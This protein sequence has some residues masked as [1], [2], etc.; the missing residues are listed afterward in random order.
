MSGLREFL[1]DSWTFQETLEEGTRAGTQIGTR[2]S[3]T[4]K[5][6]GD[7]TGSLPC[8]ARLDQRSALSGGGF[9][10]VAAV[11]GCGQYCAEEQGD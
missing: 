5:H 3:Y 4:P 2:G 11:S 1:L 10:Q 7:C 9:D 8:F 6:R